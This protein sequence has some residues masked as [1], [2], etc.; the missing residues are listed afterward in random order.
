MRVLIVDDTQARHDW[1]MRRYQSDD[2]EHAYDAPQAIEMLKRRRYD[3]VCLDHDLGGP[4]HGDGMDVVRALKALPEC[5]RP[6][7]VTVHTANPVA[8][9]FMVSSLAD[10]GIVAD[11][12]VPFV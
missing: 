8:R 5:A 11:V 10:V 6:D 3:L 12:L 7:H 1:F 2:V 9:R 4:P